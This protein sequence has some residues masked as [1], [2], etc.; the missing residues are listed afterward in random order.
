MALPLWLPSM[1][2]LPLHLEHA[3]NKVNN[4]FLWENIWLVKLTGIFNSYT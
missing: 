1:K 3:L 2:G 4:K